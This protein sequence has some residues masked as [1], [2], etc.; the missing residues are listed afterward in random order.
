MEKNWGDT[1]SATL[2]PNLAQLFV[3]NKYTVF[4]MGGTVARKSQALFLAVN[5]HGTNKHF[6]NYIIVSLWA[7][8]DQLPQASCI[9]HR[10][11]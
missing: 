10:S 3:R 9:I 2:S 1:P 5:K 11:R 6:L 8:V 7:N 4:T